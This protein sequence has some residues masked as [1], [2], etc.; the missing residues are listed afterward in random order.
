MSNFIAKGAVVLGDVEL[1]ENASIWFNAVVRADQ[2]KIHI[3]KNSNIQDNAT[4]HVEKELDVWIGDGV[5][6]GHNAIVHGCEIGDN[7]LIGM[8][9]IVM[10][11]SR[12]GMNC[13][14]G[15]GAIVTED[16]FIQDNSLVIGIPAK[17]KRK[18]TSEEIENIKINAEHYVKEAEAYK[19][20]S[21]E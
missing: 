10:N 1:G 6:V 17:V 8:G 16:S 19:K 18:L 12:I 13:I 2:R 5:T 11:R 9:A 21:C 7:T 3:G 14:I 4:V 15:A 20:L